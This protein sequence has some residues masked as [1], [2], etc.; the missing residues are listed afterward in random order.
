MPYYSLERTANE[1][2]IIANVTISEIVEVIEYAYDEHTVHEYTKYKA[3]VNS[4]YYDRLNYGEELTFIQAG[5]P[6]RHYR[7]DPLLNV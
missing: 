3:N 1:A 7:D 6:N 4:Y 5:G 2:D